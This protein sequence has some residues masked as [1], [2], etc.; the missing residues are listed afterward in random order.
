MRPRCHPWC[1]REWKINYEWL[2][3]IV[4]YHYVTWLTSNN[5]VV[6]FTTMLTH[7]HTH[8]GW[9]AG[10]NR[11][12][13][14]SIVYKVMKQCAD[15]TQEGT[16]AWSGSAN[17]HLFGAATPTDHATST[18]C[19]TRLPPCPLAPRAAPAQ[20][21]AV[22]RLSY[23]YLCDEELGTPTFSWRYHCLLSTSS[24]SVCVCVRS[25]SIG[26]NGPWRI[27]VKTTKGR[28]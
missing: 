4:S 21:A 26:S 9:R 15:I 25:A 22:A 3:A 1:H 10:T 8:A 13:K 14:H 2:P 27:D 20:R 11:Q 19:F 28:E 23:S 24:V 16:E 12:S 17:D 18:P 7:T 6:V 5:V